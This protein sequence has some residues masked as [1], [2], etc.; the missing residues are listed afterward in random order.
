MT[1]IE[2]RANQWR[3][4]SDTGSSSKF[5]WSV[6]MGAERGDKWRSNP[7]DSSDLG[8][9]V[10]LLALIPEWRPRIGEMAQHSPEWAALVPRWGELEGLLIEEAGPDARGRAPKTDALMR[11]LLTP[12][13]RG[14][15]LGGRLGG[16]RLLIE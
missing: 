14:I 7:S 2:E 3:R 10:R 16:A 1:T 12:V 9:C 13:E 5:L 4:G 11:E 8:R 6:M 15:R